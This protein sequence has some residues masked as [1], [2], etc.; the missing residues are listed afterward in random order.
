M[1]STC[2]IISNKHRYD[3]GRLYI[4]LYVCVCY[5]MS[6]SCVLRLRVLKRVWNKN[7]Q[8]YIKHFEYTLHI[9]IHIVYVIRWQNRRA[10]IYTPCRAFDRRTCAWRRFWSG[11]FVTI[12]TRNRWKFKNGITLSCC[13]TG[14]YRSSCII[15]VVR[16]RGTRT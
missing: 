9:Y 2:D 11:S 6:G 10:C 13:V 7:T 14:T 4:Y 3:N 15:R 16:L 8:E 5:G 1:F 12:A